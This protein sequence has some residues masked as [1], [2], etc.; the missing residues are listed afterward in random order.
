MVH[1][2]RHAGCNPQQVGPPARFALV[3]AVGDKATEL[4]TPHSMPA[5]VVVLLTGA[6]LPNAAPLV[7]PQINASDVR[8]L[9]LEGTGVGR[10]SA[11]GSYSITTGRWSEADRLKLVRTTRWVCSAGTTCSV[12]RMASKRAVMP[13]RLSSLSGQCPMVGS[14]S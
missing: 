14:Q 5:P 1:M 10:P 11:S 9:H 2:P 6:G 13:C 12:T 7:L 4:R 3:S 8:R